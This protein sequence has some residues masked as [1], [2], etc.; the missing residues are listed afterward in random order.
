MKKSF[1]RSV[2]FGLFALSAGIA[3]V[4]F[5]QVVRPAGTNLACAGRCSPS[6]TC[7]SACSCDFDESNDTYYCGPP[8]LRPATAP[9][10]AAR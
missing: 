6:F 2:I 5:G 10:A 8:I 4:A 7:Q 1:L 3:S 9:S